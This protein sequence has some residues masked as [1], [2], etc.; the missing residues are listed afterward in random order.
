METAG[1]GGGGPPPYDDVMSAAGGRAN[2][3]YDDE[4]SSGDN[5]ENVRSDASGG[6]TV[7][8]RVC[9]VNVVLGRLILICLVFLLGFGRGLI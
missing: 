8:C 3:G 4:H 2:A 6:P 7:T 1:S 5:Y 9:Q